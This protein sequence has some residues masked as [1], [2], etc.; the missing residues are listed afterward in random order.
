MHW[1]NILESCKAYV[2]SFFCCCGPT[3]R[4]FCAI[5]RPMR[6]HPWKIDKLIKS[7]SSQLAGQQMLNSYIL[8]LF[9]LNKRYLSNRNYASTALTVVTT[10]LVLILTN[11]EDWDSTKMDHQTSLTPLPNPFLFLFPF[12]NIDLT[13]GFQ[14]SLLMQNRP[15]WPFLNYHAR[16]KSLHKVKGTS[17]NHLRYY[18]NC[19]KFGILK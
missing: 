1:F 15:P 10:I 13:I 5:S 17:R 7:E 2:P 16:L 4:L 6:N 18:Q 14:I 12:F 9:L 11:V 3:V 19:M 8:P